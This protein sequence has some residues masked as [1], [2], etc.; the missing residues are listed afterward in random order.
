MVTNNCLGEF[1]Q[2]APVDG[3]MSKYQNVEKSYSCTTSWCHD[4]YLLPRR[5]CTMMTDTD[6][7]QVEPTKTN[8][9]SLVRHGRV[10]EWL[11]EIDQ[12]SVKNP[13]MTRIIVS[14]LVPLAIQ[15]LRLAWFSYPGNERQGIVLGYPNLECHH[16]MSR[17]RIPKKRR[18]LYGVV[19]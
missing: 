15:S 6:D 9:T 3:K 10:E 17:R 13:T 7:Q 12:V 16:S 14:Y 4:L 8:Q 5:N 1:H 2:V 18:T 19:R 11:Q